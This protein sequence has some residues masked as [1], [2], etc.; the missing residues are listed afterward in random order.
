MLLLQLS[1][2]L[3]DFF[4]M[5]YVNFYLLLASSLIYT[6]GDESTSSVIYGVN[7]E[8]FEAAED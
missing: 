6:L 8:S 1:K 7:F 4:A 3:Q 2:D 5:L